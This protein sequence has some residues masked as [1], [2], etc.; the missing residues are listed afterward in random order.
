MLNWKAFMAK[1]MFTECYD[2]KE[3]WRFIAET[4]MAGDTLIWMTSI[5]ILC[6]RHWSLTFWPLISSK[7]NQMLPARFHHTIIKIN[8]NLDWN[9]FNTNW[10]SKSKEMLQALAQPTDLS[11]HHTII[12]IH[13]VQNIRYTITLPIHCTV[14][15]FFFFFG[16]C[17][18]FWKLTFTF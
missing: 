6:T 9:K 17:F 16:D 5:W 7:S 14:G 3:M 12:E 18:T 4:N 11:F 2:K 13:Q 8:L 15:K 1:N 10:K